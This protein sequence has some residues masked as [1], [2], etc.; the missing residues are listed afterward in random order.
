MHMKGLSVGVGLMPPVLLLSLEEEEEEEEGEGPG[1]GGGSRMQ[2][3]PKATSAM[4]PGTHWN[5]TVSATP[6][7]RTV[8]VDAV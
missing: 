5:A 8:H 6:G 4:S 2:N 3:D 7:G 1:A